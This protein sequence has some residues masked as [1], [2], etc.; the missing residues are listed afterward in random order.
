ML[1]KRSNGIWRLIY[2]LWKRNLWGVFLDEVQF[3]IRKH[4]V[5]D[6]NTWLLVF[7]SNMEDG[8]NPSVLRRPVNP[9]R[10][11]E[12]SW[13]LCAMTWAPL[14]SQ[15]DQWDNNPAEETI[16]DCITAFNS[17]SLSVL[18][19]ALLPATRLLL[20]ST[21]G[22]QLDG[23]VRY[24]NISHNDTHLQRRVLIMTSDCL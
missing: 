3:E 23:S 4:S 15:I 16:D 10:N 2:W 19:L 22:W 9:S 21:Y 8:N 24:Q 5:V 18:S 20:L 11:T 7:V 6:R 12:T 1:N 17:L 14:L 13:C